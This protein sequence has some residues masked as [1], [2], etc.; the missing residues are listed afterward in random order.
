MTDQTTHINKRNVTLW[1][2]AFF[3]AMGAAIWLSV[4]FDLGGL[5]STVLMLLATLM[6]IPMVSAAQKA[7]KSGGT[8]TPA[9]KRY[10]RRFIAMSLGYVGLLMMSV[11]LFN[12]YQIAGPALWMLALLPTLPVMGMV[13][14]MARL[15]IEEDDEYQRQKT[16]NAALIATGI[17]LVICT[18]WGFLETFGLVPHVW[19]WATFPIWAI[20]LG[21][22][23]MMVRDKV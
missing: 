5:W 14:A 18:L 4:A 19:L 1:V 8:M 16:V 12:A 23:Q 21:V 11:G 2:L 17:T 10:N 3:A 15:V 20:G 6:L 22:G 13:W 7:A 9:T